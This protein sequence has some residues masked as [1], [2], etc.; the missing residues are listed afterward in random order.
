MWNIISLL[1]DIS[2]MVCDFLYL[3]DRKKAER[4]TLRGAPFR[5]IPVIQMQPGEK[6]VQEEE[7]NTTCKTKEAK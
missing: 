3:R 5:K 6:A 7:G 1:V 4:K 2:S